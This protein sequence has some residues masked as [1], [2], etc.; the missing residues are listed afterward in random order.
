MVALHLRN[1]KH[2]FNLEP[3]NNHIFLLIKY[4]AD[5]YTNI[6]L[7]FL[8][9]ETSHCKRLRKTLGSFSEV[10]LYSSLKHRCNVA[11]KIMDREKSP[12]D[13][14][15]KFVPRELS[16]LGQVNHDNIIKMYEI[17]EM[18]GRRVGI[19]MEAAA[20]DLYKKIVE[21]HRIPERQSKTMFSQM[22]SAINYLHQA[23]IVHRDLKCENVLLTAQEQI[24]ITDF[25]FSRRC[26]DPSELVST[27]CGT[28]TYYPPEIIMGRPYDPKK[29]DIWSLA[30][31]LFCMLTGQVP[32]NAASQSRLLILQQKPLV[33]PKDVAFG[34]PCRELFRAML[35]YDPPKRPTIQEVAEHPW[36]KN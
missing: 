22:V 29:Y 10:K 14:V 28:L 13:F 17:I 18:P 12:A 35:Q 32:F 27:F 20:K 3:Y 33:Y 24:K 19:V 36:L 8:A 25:G 4:I 21:V 6:R 5:S 31:I 1:L 9:K 34:E 7:H 26:H 30:V 23:G 2:T 16:I 15:E 11:I